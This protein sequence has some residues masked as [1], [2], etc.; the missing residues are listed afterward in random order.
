MLQTTKKAA[1]FSM[2]NY[3]VFCCNYDDIA[4]L[5]E[6]PTFPDNLKC[7]SDKFYPSLFDFIF[8]LYC[9]GYIACF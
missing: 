6:L 1:D 3:D 2:F 7:E 8:I 5:W 4:M 9:V